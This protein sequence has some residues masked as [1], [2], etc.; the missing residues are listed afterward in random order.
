MGSKDFERPNC[1][2]VF[3]SDENEEAVVELKCQLDDMTG[4]EMGHALNKL[5][6][7]GALDTYITPIVMKKSRPA[8]ELTVI[9]YPDKK[10]FFIK[11]YVFFD[12]WIFY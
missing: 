7:L 1:V 11:F 3:A 2:R 5:L 10:D 8:F 9:T 12:S 4:E 6:S